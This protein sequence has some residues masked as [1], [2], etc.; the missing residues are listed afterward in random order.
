MKQLKKWLPFPFVCAAL[1]LMILPLGNLL[2][3]APEPN[4]QVVDAFSWF[5]GTAWGYGQLFPLPAAILTAGS[6]ILLLVSILTGRFGTA[7]LW[8]LALATV[9]AVLSLFTAGARNGWGILT[10]VLLVLAAITQAIIRH[11]EKSD[12][13]S[14]SPGTNGKPGAQ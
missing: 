5:D 10:A 8:L 14:A 6:S 3:F 2:V 1:V 12:V 7:F 4:V 9:F 13:F 11:G